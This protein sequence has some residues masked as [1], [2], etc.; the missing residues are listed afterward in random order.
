VDFH[1]LCI[2]G[3][4][5]DGADHYAIRNLPSGGVKVFVWHDDP[6]DWPPGQRWARVSTIPLLGVDPAMG[7]AINT[8][9][10]DVIYAEAGIRPTFAAAYAGNPKVEVVPWTRFTPPQAKVQHGVWVPDA[11]HADLQAAR[12]VVGWR[13]WTEGLDPRELDARGCVKQQCVNVHYLPPDG[14]RTYYNDSTAGPIIHAADFNNEAVLSPTGSTN[15]TAAHNQN[16]NTHCTAVTEAG[17]PD[18]AA[19]PTTGVYRYQI[20]VTAIG[21]DLEYGML[22]LGS[23]IG[24]FSR[25]ASDGLSDLETFAQ[26]QAAFTGSGLNIGSVTNPA[27]TAGSVND[28][29]SI[30][31]ACDRVA[32]H[33]NQNMTVQVGELDDFMDGPWAAPATPTMGNVIMNGTT[34]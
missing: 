33:G 27:W 31:L 26:D 20:D 11:Q 23:G 30:S 10:T 25:A 4:T 18:S 29:F 6:D 13:E 19:W 15:Q 1:A 3:V 5:F 7:G 9:A 28:R 32:G 2:Q 12:R 21:A 22:N 17:E 24:H 34:F 16:G 14:T 8:R